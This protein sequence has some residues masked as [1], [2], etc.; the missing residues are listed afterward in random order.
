M[1]IGVMADSHENMPMIAKAVEIFN[2]ER[3]AVV[4]H[5]GDIISPITAKEFKELRC[6]LIAVFGNNDGDKLFLREKCQGV[7]EIY[8]RKWEGDLDG[9]RLLLIH[10][11]DMLEALRESGAYD[12][13][14]Y[15]H[16]HEADLRRGPTLVVNPGECGG[17]LTGRCT[18]AIIDT[19]TMTAEVR[20]LQAD[21]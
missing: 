17:W 6:G 5:A 15:G 8:E 10:A 21:V 1:K 3:V 12:I 7:G 16:T 20:D 2:S 18:V 19:E 11:P 13:I 14:V 4:L 9:K